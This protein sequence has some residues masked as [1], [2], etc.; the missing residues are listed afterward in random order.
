MNNPVQ[1]RASVSAAPESAQTSRSAVPTREELNAWVAAVATENDQQ[2]FIALFNHFA[3]RIKGFLARSGS[4]LEVADDLAQET[5]IRV[6]RHAERFDARRAALS[7]WIFTIARNLRTDQHRL[8]TTSGCRQLDHGFDI[9]D[10]DQQSADPK[11]GPAE[12]C[13]AAQLEQCL[14]RAL[15]ELPADQV[16]LLRLSFFDDQPHATIARELGIPLGTVKSRIRFAVEQLRRK[17]GRS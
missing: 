6:W 10:D 13:L 7:T 5:M 8:N 9:W 15:A 16:L 3:P 11:A 4:P 12:L 17:L 2:A 1:L 14:Y